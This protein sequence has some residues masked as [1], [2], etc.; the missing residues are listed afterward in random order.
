MGEST[1]IEY[2]G[3]RLTYDLQGE[4][5]P[6]LLIQGVGVHGLTV[7]CADKV[8]ALLLAHLAEAERQ[9]NA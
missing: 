9:P 8:N 7:Q 2:Q 1:S 4:G 3:C 6:V 5:P